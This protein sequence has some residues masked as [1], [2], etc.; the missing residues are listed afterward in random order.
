MQI[1]NSFI[2]FSCEAGEEGGVYIF[3]GGKTFPRGN[4]A[5]FHCLPSSLVKPCPAQSV[6]FSCSLIFQKTMFHLNTHVML[7]CA[8]KMMS[9]FQAFSWQT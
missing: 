1:Y 3:L 6:S 9:L 4:N 7:K 5:T 2:L 8:E